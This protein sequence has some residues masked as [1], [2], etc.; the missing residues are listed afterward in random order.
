MP[1]SVCRFEIDVS[2]FVISDFYPGTFYIDIDS[3]D[4]HYVATDATVDVVIIISG[5]WPR[6]RRAV[7]ETGT[8]A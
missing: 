1:L 3:N 5:L 6:L 7:I 8:L 2:E 4:V